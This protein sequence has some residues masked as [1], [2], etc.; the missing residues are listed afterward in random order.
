MEAKEG[1]DPPKPWRTGTSKRFWALMNEARHKQALDLLRSLVT[2]PASYDLKPTNLFAEGDAEAMYELSWIH[3]DG[4]YGVKHSD[5]AVARY[6]L[7]NAAHLGHPRAVVMLCR[8][9]M[10]DYEPAFGTHVL[11]C[12]DPLAHFLVCQ[13]LGAIGCPPPMGFA[14]LD[15]KTFSWTCL[16]AAMAQG[17]PEAYAWA[18]RYEKISAV[19]AALRGHPAACLQY[20]RETVPDRV[21]SIRS[22]EIFRSNDAVFTKLLHL[23]AV[24]G[25]GSC[26]FLLAKTLKSE[27][28]HILAARL[29]VTHPSSYPINEWIQQ[30]RKETP[31]LSPSEWYVYGKWQA[32][33]PQ[34]QVDPTFKYIEL[35]RRVRTKAQR[36][37]VAL[38]GWFRRR[39]FEAR[40]PVHRHIGQAI[41]Q[42][43][44]ESREIQT[45]EWD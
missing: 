42:M 27:G 5:G 24:Q 7:M 21:L 17:D 13:F 43:V 18:A 14:N 41:A 23:G 34:M 4:Y 6:W 31:P 36:A 38:L 28:K 16:G 8:S 35:Y 15:L 3:R 12:D 20:M 32:H 11:V 19:D 10:L 26:V 37:T 39:R 30:R 33:T 40:V 45:D 44:W 1:L 2:E 22:T 25:V 9:D 29:I